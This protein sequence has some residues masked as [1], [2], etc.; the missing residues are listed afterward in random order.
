MSIAAHSLLE[1]EMPVAAESAQ[2]SRCCTLGATL[3]PGG[4]N[5]SVYSRSASGM[6]VLLFDREDDARPSRVIP[7]DPANLTYH[8]WHVYVPGVRA[9]QIYGLRADGPLDPAAG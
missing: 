3:A 5:F 9:G 1:R 7:I 8:Y 4:V 6:E 2:N